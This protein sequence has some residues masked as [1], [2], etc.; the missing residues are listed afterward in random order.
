MNIKY[1]G[2]GEVARF[3]DYG[4]FPVTVWYHKSGSKTLEKL[5]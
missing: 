4:R 1:A 5:F 2:S 3:R